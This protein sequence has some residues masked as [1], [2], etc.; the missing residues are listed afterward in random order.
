[1]EMGKKIGLLGGTFDPIHLG[2]LNL[3]MEIMEKK[4][5]DEVWFIPAHINPHK[6]ESPPTSA[7]D[8]RLE[9]LK[10][11][12]QDIPS[13]KV[14]DIE[15]QLPS[16]SYTVNTV[17]HILKE[18]SS[19]QFYLLLGED[20]IPGFIHWY[21][22]EEIVKMVP[23]LIGSRS[24]NWHLSRKEGQ[25]EVYEAIQKG[26]VRTRLLDISSTELRKRLSEGLYCGH[27]IPPQ[28]LAYIN[29]NQLYS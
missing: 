1:M 8:H 23:L 4:G 12:L 13:F 29:Q 16:P 10:L 6:L 17:K 11:A 21:R 24:G 18:N 26:L 3:A 14:V 22:P 7:P 25:E 9:M 28:V 5:L 27:L 15:H 19:D 2:H 20:S